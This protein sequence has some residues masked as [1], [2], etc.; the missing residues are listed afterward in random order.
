MTF[1][2]S[3]GRV[4]SPTFQPH[5]VSGG[6]F[7]P[8]DIS[9]CK[10]WLDFADPDTMFT[11]D[12]STKVANDGDKIYR[13]NDKSGNN[14]HAKQTNATDRPQYKTGIK[15]GLSSGLFINYNKMPLPNELRDLLTQTFTIFA[16]IKFL[17][18]QGG[19]YAGIGSKYYSANGFLILKHS[20][21]KM[22]FTWN[23]AKYI[24]SNTSI[25]DNTWYLIG[26]KFDHPNT[27]A[28]LFINSSLENSSSNTTVIGTGATLG[29]G[30]ETH[31]NQYFSEVVIYNSALSDSDRGKVQTY[32]NN[33]WAIY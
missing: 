9:G 27:Y 5:S 25:A 14:Y 20:N 2:S 6:K 10:L 1:S 8:T 13:I 17:S 18:V 21:N 26:A 33:K 19:G 29:I 3:F 28:G 7:K 4:F 31:N 22:M 24:Y 23:S 16:V 12:G 30:V 11:D 32:L 15:N